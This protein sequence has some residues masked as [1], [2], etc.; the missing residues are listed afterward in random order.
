MAV[1]DQ[2]SPLKLKIV[3]LERSMKEARKQDLK[4]FQS[5][6]VQRPGPG[7]YDKKQVDKPENVQIYAYDAEG[8]K[9]KGFEC[10]HVYVGFYSNSGC[11]IQVSYAHHA[12]INPLV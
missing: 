8:E 7:Q 11:R 10:D 9:L 5:S 3:Y 2:P 12:G 1:K 4:V 6:S